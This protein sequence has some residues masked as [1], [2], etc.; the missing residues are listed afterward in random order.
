MES[1]NTVKK[2]KEKK[3]KRKEVNPRVYHKNHRQYNSSSTNKRIK[4][5]FMKGL[6]G[7]TY[8]VIENLIS[9]PY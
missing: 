6:V 2:R 9:F 1:G 5:K 3:K 4:S 8:R 7:V